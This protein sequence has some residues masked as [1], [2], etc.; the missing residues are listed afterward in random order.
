MT[1]YEQ[2][3]ESGKGIVHGIL[4]NLAAELREP[5]VDNLKFNVTDQ[6]FDHDRISLMD[7]QFNMVAKIQVDDL[8][9]CPAD[10]AVRRRLE[11]RLRQAVRAHFGRRL[12]RVPV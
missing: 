7:S 3:V 9:D 12:P 11:A 10:N 5:E 1:E 2:Q 8:A 6:D 4:A